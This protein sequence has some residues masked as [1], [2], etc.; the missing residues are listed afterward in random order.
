M[1][2]RDVRGDPSAVEEESLPLYFG[3]WIKLRRQELDLT[4][5]QLAKRA[6]CTVFTVR[7]IESGERRPSRQLAGLLAQALEIPCENQSTFFKVARGEL[8]L[9]RL[10]SPARAPSPPGGP[11]ARPA[12]ILGSLPRAL[13]PF[14]GREP[15][16]EALNHLIRDPG[17]SLLTILGPG[18]IG[19]TRLAIEAA[20][21][22]RETF[23]DGAWF[24][25]LAAL[26]SPALLVPAIADAVHFRFQNPANPKAQLQ[27]YLRDKR[28]LL[29]LDNAEHL[30]DGA[31]AFIEILEACP[32][33]KLL[34]TSRERLNLLSE[35]V[36]EIGGLP[37]PAS[38]QVEQFEIYSSVA[39]FLQSVRRA[40]AG[41]ELREGD[42]KYVLKICQV[43]EGMPLG[44]EL[45]AGWV[46]TLSTAEIAAEMENSLDFLSTSARDVPERQRSMRAVFDHSWQMLSPDEQQVLRQLSVFRGGFTR[47]AAECVTGIKLDLLSSLLAKS[48]IQRE[49]QTRYSLHELVRQYAARQL[50]TAG[51]LEGVQRRH[52]AFF[53][54]FAE[55]DR[56]EIGGSLV[57]ALIKRMESDIDNLR[58]ALGYSI[59]L[60]ASLLA[61][62][63]GD[64]LRP[65][66]EFRGLIDEGRRCWNILLD[67]PG[68]NTKEYVI[69]RGKALQAAGV[70]ARIQGDFEEA[71]HLYQESLDLLRQ[72]GDPKGVA[73]VLNSLGVL[74][75][76][77]GKYPEAEALMLESLQLC[78]ELDNKI[79]IGRRLNDLAVVATHQGAYEKARLLLDESTQIFR[80]L[81]DRHGLAGSLDNLGVVLGYQGKYDRSMEVL[82]ESLALGREIGD[83]QSLVIVLASIA[84][85]H[86]AMGNASLALAEFHESLTQNQ[87]VGDMNTLAACLEGIAEALELSARHSPLPEDCIRLAIRLLAAADRV[88]TASGASHSPAESAENE[89]IIAQ[90]RSQCTEPDFSLE[91]KRGIDMTTEQVVEFT[92]TYLSQRSS[93]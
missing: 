68:D 91:W 76:Y 17:C 19:K 56:E 36:F 24:I 70:L 10:P 43:V 48:L 4:Q 63:I 93:A 6:S 84:R 28:A 92:L 44:I 20:S 31:V 2:S 22:T 60:H 78:R 82:E 64:I 45:S 30:L 7:K 88:L 23:P 79:E 13:T 61:L 29:V 57:A 80:A 89:R 72:S 86:L 73:V 9:E 27:N 8:S 32:Q 15:E 55:K 25:P 46:G 42:R 77:E 81:N 71:H 49:G 54:N 50:E 5:A 74:T 66:W 21:R 62:R 85:V 65:F 38:H 75:M 18:G 58:A 41:F 3:E 14:I 12:S 33:I 35:W 39:L 59:S 90:L 16:L 67:L 53:I 37:V 34:V 40:Q 1:G 69:Q 87:Q 47:E 83:V 26:N 11:P 51:E 52:I